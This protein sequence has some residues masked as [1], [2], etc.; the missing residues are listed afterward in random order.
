MPCP[1]CSKRP[2]DTLDLLDRPIAFHRVFVTITGS[3]NAALM[4]SQ[5]I[6][7]SKRTR[8][9]D[10]WF[11]KSAKEWEEET[12]LSRHMQDAARALLDGVLETKLAGMPA[13]VHFRVSAGNLRTWLAQNVKQDCRKPANKVS[14]NRQTSNRS[15][16]TSENTPRK[17]SASKPGYVIQTDQIALQLASIWGRKAATPW[18]PKEIK[19]YGEAERAGLM[20]KEHVERYAYFHKRCKDATR[21]PY[22]RTALLTALNH[23]PGECDKAEGFWNR[24]HKEPRPPAPARPEPAPKPEP[25]PDEETL[26][27]RAI[28]NQQLADRKKRRTGQNGT[29][30]PLQDRAGVIASDSDAARTAPSPSTSK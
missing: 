8:D 23:W 12:G 20:T 19:A 27:Q 7:W 29:G 9:R 6:Y 25:P 15:E 1:A 21:P 11:Y 10:G 16:N 13:T 4:L 26:R 18:N 5:A 30:R 22:P 24:H 3:I 2:M 17:R 14:D 28:F